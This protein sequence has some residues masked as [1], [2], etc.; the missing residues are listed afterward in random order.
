RLASYFPLETW[1]PKAKSLLA[2]HG[3]ISFIYPSK[4][5]KLLE[6]VARE[7]QLSMHRICHVKPS[8]SKPS[9][10]LLVELRAEKPSEIQRSEICLRPNG[11]ND[12]HEDYISLCKDFYLKM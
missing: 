11:S 3:K 12:Y 7:N 8:P 9:H 6:Q 10:R 1:I 5:I 4:E 2:E